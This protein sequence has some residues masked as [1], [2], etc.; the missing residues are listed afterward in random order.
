MYKILLSF[1]LLA[2][3][4]VPSAAAVRIE[5]IRID[6]PGPDHDEYFELYGEPGLSL[7]GYCYVVLGDG[8]GACGSVETIVALDGLIL[9]EDG[10]LCVV[11]EESALVASVRRSLD[12]ENNDDV[13][14]LLVRG[15]TGKLNDDLDVDD[16][17]KLDRTPWAEVLD[18][19][20]FLEGT[21]PDCVTNEFAYALVSIPPQ[22]HFVAGHAFRCG[23]YWV[24]GNFEFGSF[25]TPGEPNG[26]SAELAGVPVPP[27]DAQFLK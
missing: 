16:D 18:A 1:L 20:S 9:G 26:C 11:E 19:V 10:Y 23:G 24:A 27:G 5:E 7:D 21:G 4:I 12:F 14:H 15:F 22:G 6:Q 8:P 13:T 25:D 2:L 3:F 17:G